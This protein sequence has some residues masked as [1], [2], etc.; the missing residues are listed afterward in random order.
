MAGKTV[1]V[2]YRQM[3]ASLLEICLAIFMTTVAELGAH[4][5][6]AERQS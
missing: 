3:D 1:A 2:F 4:F 6:Y 5:L